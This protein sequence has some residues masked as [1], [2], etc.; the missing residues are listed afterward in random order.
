M[1]DESVTIAKGIGII[2]MVIG[3][4]GLDGY[5]TRLIYMFHMPLFFFLSGFCFKRVIYLLPENLLCAVLR[6][7]MYPL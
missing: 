7:F 1:K 3:H 6:V 4:S 2:L 5:P